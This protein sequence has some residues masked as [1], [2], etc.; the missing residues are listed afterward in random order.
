MYASHVFDTGGQIVVVI[1]DD[2]VMRNDLGIIIATCGLVQLWKEIC[3]ELWEKMCRKI[4]H[5]AQVWVVLNFDDGSHMCVMV[6]EAAQR[7]E[8]IIRSNA[9]ANTNTVE[10]RQTCEIRQIGVA[11][12]PKF[13]SD[14][15][16]ALETCESRQIGV[17]PDPQVAS[18]HCEVRQGRQVH[19]RRSIPYRKIAFH[20]TYVARLHRYVFIHEVRVVVKR[21]P[22]E[23]PPK[24][25][26]TNHPCH[27]HQVLGFRFVRD[28]L[29][30]RPTRLLIKHVLVLRR[31]MPHVDTH[32]KK[33]HYKTHKHSSCHHHNTPPCKVL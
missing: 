29:L 12:D 32:L 11:P 21:G 19:H 18:N 6:S 28:D 16:D 31:H 2:E 30:H 5:S 17:A 24:S 22:G 4:T 7:N 26:V 15:R 1:V 9:Y 20:T 23:V 27:A 33:E 3:L 25:E 14:G 13:A 10:I 8:I